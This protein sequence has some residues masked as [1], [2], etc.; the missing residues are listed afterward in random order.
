MGLYS[1]WLIHSIQVFT[2][3]ESVYCSYMALFNELPYVEIG[4]S[5]ML[6]FFF[7]QSDRIA[8]SWNGKNLDFKPMNVEEAQR[9]V[10]NQQKILMAYVDLDTNIVFKL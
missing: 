9:Y 8:N 3:L 1:Q 4:F 10:S 2:N 6:C 5:T 7:V